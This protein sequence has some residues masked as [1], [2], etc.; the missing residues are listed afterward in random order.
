MLTVRQSELTWLNELYII[1]C[2]IPLHM[3]QRGD[4]HELGNQMILSAH[5]A[6]SYRDRIYIIKDVLMKLVEYGQLN[7]TTLISFCGLNLSKHRSILEELEDRGL[8][9]RQIEMVGKKRAVSVFRPTIS[10][11]EFC[12]SILEPYETMFPRKQ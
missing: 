6:A 12:K 10:G 5:H 7:Q 8:I 11:I 2:T 9:S 1:S 3:S 4:P